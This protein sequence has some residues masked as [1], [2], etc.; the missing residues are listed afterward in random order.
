MMAQ[1]ALAQH[2]VAKTGQ[3]SSHQHYP[4]MQ[5]KPNSMEDKPIN[6][7]IN[8]SQASCGASTTNHTPLT[9]QQH[10]INIR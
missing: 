9:H 5:K 3:K 7:L 1:V 4:V 6:G 10:F 8:K 2:R